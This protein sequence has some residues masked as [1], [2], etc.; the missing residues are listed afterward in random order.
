MI[1]RPIGQ[2]GYI[3]KS[4]KTEIIIDPYLS[5]VVNKVAG[6]ARMLPSPI[7]PASITA[8]AVICTHDHLDHLD[9]ESVK[10]MR[11][12]Q[13]FLTTEEGK[14]TLSQLGQS[15][16]TA[17]KIGDQ[18]T[19][20]DLKLK[21]VYAKHSCEA[22]GLIVKDKDFTLYFSGDTLYDEKLSEIAEEKPDI[23]F[24]CINGRL[25]NMTVEEAVLTAEQ[26]GAKV[27]IPNHYDM[28]ASNTEDPKKF[29]APNAKILEFNKE[30]SVEELLR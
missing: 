18:I 13:F 19:L 17:V 21:A 23:A 27:N 8:D 2:S 15:N 3:V 25:G 7:D 14:E 11:K 5:D 10:E 29:T 9:T 26:I 1:I 4:G 22:F 12:E 20:G 30:Y 28:F 24:L 6:R 16:V